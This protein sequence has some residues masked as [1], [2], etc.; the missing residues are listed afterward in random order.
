[1]DIV[2]SNRILLIKK[3]PSQRVLE[4]GFVGFKEIENYGSG[5]LGLQDVSMY[6]VDFLLK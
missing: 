5:Y 4:V 3:Y 6:T 1:M 2:N